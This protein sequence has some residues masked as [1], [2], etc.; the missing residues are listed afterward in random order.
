MTR[1]AGRRLNVQLMGI[2]PPLGFNARCQP[3]FAVRIQQVN[4]ADFL[5]VKTDRV[6]GKL[7]RDCRIFQDFQGIFHDHFAKFLNHGGNG[8]FFI[9]ITGKGIFRVA[10]L[11]RGRNPADW[12]P[13]A[14]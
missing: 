12:F 11:F 10:F 3:E 1:F 13:S 2:N 5:E 14:R 6:F 4:Q 9:V 8:A 7:N